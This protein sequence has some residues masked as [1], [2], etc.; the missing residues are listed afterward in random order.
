M[1]LRYHLYYTTG[2]ACALY[3]NSQ[4]RTGSTPSKPEDFV[5]DVIKG[6]D[7]P[8][9]KRQTLSQQRDALFAWAKSMGTRVKYKKKKDK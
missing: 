8:K 9:K 3:A 4:K 5:P 2:I 1:D 6:V 7:R